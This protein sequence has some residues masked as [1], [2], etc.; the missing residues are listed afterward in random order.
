MEGRLSLGGL[1]GGV[2]SG[3]AHP[4]VRGV[5]PLGRRSGLFFWLLGF[6]LSSLSEAAPAGPLAPAAVAQVTGAAVA[7]RRTIW[8]P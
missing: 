3:S 8:L 1:D 2:G 7:L 4:G 5:A 6:Q